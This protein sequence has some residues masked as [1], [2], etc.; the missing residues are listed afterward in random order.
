VVTAVILV[1]VTV[2]AETVRRVVTL[3]VVT[4]VW[5]RCGSGAAVW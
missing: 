4:V 5:Q 2:A 1:T 3:T